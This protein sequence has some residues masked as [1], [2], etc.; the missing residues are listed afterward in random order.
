MPAAALF[1][2]LIAD[3][4]Q[5]LAGG[6][7]DQSAPQVI[8]VRQVGKSL[9]LRSTAEAVEGD[10]GDVLFVRRTAWVALQFLAG[11]VQSRAT[12]APRKVFSEN[13]F[14]SARPNP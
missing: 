14:I 7:H 13:A 11:E 6:E 5:G 3:Q 4:M 2:T 8:A 12:G 1:P 9:L 10:K